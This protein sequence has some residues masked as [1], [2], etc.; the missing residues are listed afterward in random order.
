VGTERSSQAAGIRVGARRCEASGDLLSILLAMA[1]QR[2]SASNGNPWLDLVCVGILGLLLWWGAQA[3]AAVAQV[4]S[5][6]PA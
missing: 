4:S 1:Q 6:H 2:P 5:T 3:I